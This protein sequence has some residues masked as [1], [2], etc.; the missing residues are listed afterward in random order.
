MRPVC[1]CA[2]RRLAAAGLIV[3]AALAVSITTARAEPLPGDAGLLPAG[4]DLGE[5]A[6]EAP[7]QILTVERQGG[8]QSFLVA[9]GNLAFSAP[10]VLGDPARRAGISCASCHVGGEANPAFFLPGHSSRP[11]NVDVTG[12]FFNPEA[13]D[14]LLN[15]LDIPSLRGSRHSAP[16]GRDGRSA[17]LREFTREVIVTEFAGEEPL[18]AV[19]DGLVAYMRQFELLPNPKLGPGGRLTEVASGAA[20]RGEALFHESFEGMGGVSC[21]SCHV[22]SAMFLDG[23]SHDVGTGGYY[24]TPTLLNVDFTPP[25]FHDGRAAGLADVVEH[26]NRHFTLGLQAGERADLV[27][28]LE[29]VGDGQ[30]PTERT[31]LAFEMAELEIFTGLLDRTLADR[32][33]PLTRL[34]VDTVNRELRKVAERWYRAADRRIRGRIAGWA[35]QLRRVATLAEEGNRQAAGAALAD[36]RTLVAAGIGE[37][38]TAEPRST[39]DPTI[40]DRYLRELRGLAGAGG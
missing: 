14:S 13:D 32:D 35:V 2:G 30:T 20:R 15:P 27:A 36:Y 10:D 18:P 29:A 21:A 1:G 7:R 37:V 33:V 25:Y 22:P 11:G 38:A 19:L 12:P 3:G 23:R 24:D 8:R 26:F 28:Y 34:V 6:L 5:P 39:Y 40:L 17:S 31:D 4:T 16:Y 9:L